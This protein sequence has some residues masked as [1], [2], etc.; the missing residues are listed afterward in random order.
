MVN[1]EYLFF[2]ARDGFCVWVCVFL[3]FL[4]RLMTSSAGGGGARW[5]CAFVEC[6]AKFN[7]NVG[8]AFQLVLDEIDKSQVGWLRVIQ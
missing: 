4:F 3:L 2:L 6:S 8:T 5:G 1:E 7:H